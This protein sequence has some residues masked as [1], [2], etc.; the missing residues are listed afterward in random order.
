MDYD[1]FMK[2]DNLMKMD[3]G[4]LAELTYNAVAILYEKLY[5]YD[6]I[7]IKKA[8]KALEW[9]F[10]ISS[11]CAGMRESMPFEQMLINQSFVDDLDPMIGNYAKDYEIPEEDLEYDPQL[12]MALYFLTF[13]DD[14]INH[15]IKHDC[16]ACLAEK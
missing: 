11:E 9:V 3:I 6:D 10:K 1:D 14:L 8:K 15:D 5:D 13:I 12:V 16:L 2:M 7:D 4:S